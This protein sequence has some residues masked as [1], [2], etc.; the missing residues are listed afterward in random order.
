[1]SINKLFLVILKYQ[2]ICFALI[3]SYL[4]LLS[5]NN[6]L[7]SAIASDSDSKESDAGNNKGDVI[8]KYDSILVSSTS[9]NPYI[10][11]IYSP[12]GKYLAYT[13][14]YKIVVLEMKS[15]GV[16]QEIMNINI[17]RNK[18]QNLI[19]S[20]DDRYLITEDGSENINVY[21]LKVGKLVRSL[22]VPYSFNSLLNCSHNGK[23]L[24]SSVK[25]TSIVIWDIQGEPSE[26][27]QIKALGSHNTRLEKVIFSPNDEYLASS[28]TDGIIKIWDLHGDPTTWQEKQLLKGH[29]T[30]VNDLDFSSSGQL[31]SGSSDHT[32]K[33][34]DIEK[35]IELRSFTIQNP[36]PI[37]RLKYSP[38]AN[39]IVAS[40][41]RGNIVTFDLNSDKKNESKIFESESDDYVNSLALSPDNQE[42]VI[43][44]EGSKQISFFK[45]GFPASSTANLTL[46]AEIAKMLNVNVNVNVEG[47]QNLS[48]KSEKDKSDSKVETK[49]DTPT[50]K[51]TV[52][53]EESE[54]DVVK[55][56][57]KDVVKDVEKDRSNNREKLLNK[58]KSHKQKVEALTNEHPIYADVVESVFNFLGRVKEDPVHV[59]PLFIIISGPAGS[60]KSLLMDRL[61]EESGQARSYKEVYIDKANALPIKNIIS[62]MAEPEGV[63]SKKVNFIFFDE[64]QNIIPQGSVREM[65]ASLK[66][67]KEEYATLSKKRNEDGLKL[68][69]ETV[70][71]EGKEISAP[72]TDREQ[73]LK[74][75]IEELSKKIT[76]IIS[77][78]KESFDFIQRAMGTG[79]FEHKSEYSVGKYIEL[80][81][82][83]RGTLSDLAINIKSANNNI[84]LIKA[85]IEELEKNTLLFKE[86]K[87]TKENTELSKTIGKDSKTIEEEIKKLK[88]ELEKQEKIVQ[89]ATKSRND[90]TV[91]ELSKLFSSLTSDYPKLLGN[92]LNNNNTTLMASEFAT[93]DDSANKY[94]NTMIAKSSEIS[95]DSKWTVKR[96]VIVMALNNH[97]LIE[98]VNNRFRGSNKTI[99]PDEYRKA[100][101]EEANDKE[102]Q[103]LISDRL[104]YLELEQEFNDLM[105]IEK[106][107]D[108]QQRT[109]QTSLSSRI[110]LDSA[111]ET[112]PP[113]KSEWLK[114][115]S[116][117]LST[118]DSYVIKKL[119]K[120]DL[121]VANIKYS[122]RI[123]NFI[124]D[125]TSSA[126]GVYRSFSPRFSKLMGSFSEEMLEKLA[127][128]RSSEVE[129]N[130]LRAAGIIETVNIEVDSTNEDPALFIAKCSWKNP[131][132]DLQSREL[133]RFKTKLLDKEKN[134]EEENISTKDYIV[135]ANQIAAVLTFGMNFFQSPPT[136]GVELGKHTLDPNAIKML[137]PNRSVK[138]FTYDYRLNMSYL[139]SLAAASV[140]NFNEQKP[141][142][143]NYRE[144]LE[145][146]LLKMK[147]SIDN[148]RTNRTF[149]TKS[150]EK[151]PKIPLDKIIGKELANSPFFK[152]LDEVTINENGVKDFGKVMQYLSDHAEIF[153]KKYYDVITALAQ[154]IVKKK[155]SVQNNLQN[156][157]P[158]DGVKFTTREIK[159]VIKNHWPQIKN[160]SFFK[161]SLNFI[162]ALLPLSLPPSLCYD[163]D[164]VLDNKVMNEVIRKSP[165]GSCN[166]DLCTNEHYNPTPLHHSDSTRYSLF[167]NVLNIITFGEYDRINDPIFN[168]SE[169]AENRVLAPIN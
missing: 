73:E 61:K 103:K 46:S 133:L 34:W 114:I 101:A 129:N 16:R 142:N 144:S 35:G 139:A 106:V 69:M 116:N 102:L 66:K 121:Q 134:F 91:G 137:W 48:N 151:I 162:T 71:K 58:L 50:L 111:K 140:L 13:P 88:I 105:G 160:N 87:E 93:S 70:K 163:K 149:D 167:E 78:K 72:V 51:M 11:A 99:D 143:R 31:I 79:N 84:A 2:I 23:Y 89:S 159:R 68:A 40:T 161:R 9:T 64:I 76:V 126:I 62:A 32:V 156:N 12:S 110:N 120:S 127:L 166:I 138:N 146:E 74:T 37:L 54:K 145:R 130:N 97:Q 155:M 168:E 67:L 81:S 53:D 152:M 147:N 19:F 44:S 38:N 154:E 86:T 96:S 60:G 82:K 29:T 157:L 42:L 41:T 15:N 80:F 104:N 17:S 49:V 90:L 6:S 118:N 4:N 132:G 22:P 65:I 148:D 169:F 47:P 135:V 98:R 94:L 3:F 165:A 57:V 115:V 92:L 117:A 141:L 150:S 21:D 30:Y 1:M 77:D 125:N 100:Y 108:R 75:K 24:A 107:E 164:S 113:G 14:N 52:K 18:T 28:S 5:F 25:D 55:N 7:M 153:V 158:N 27:K 124:Y 39:S 122:D 123:K 10:T 85:K 131:T 20:A 36:A 136:A 45:T 119:A 63:K 59:N 26:W 43:T 109:T 128:L 33:I 83:H 95:D 112:L 56:I 8:K